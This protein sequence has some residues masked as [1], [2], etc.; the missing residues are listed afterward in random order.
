[1]NSSNNS[2]VLNDKV[3]YCS[4]G[5]FMPRWN[6][7]DRMIARSSPDRSIDFRPHTGGRRC[8]IRS[9]R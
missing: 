7:S 4:P 3:I 9:G 2:A 6:Y 1:M 8:Q 5:N